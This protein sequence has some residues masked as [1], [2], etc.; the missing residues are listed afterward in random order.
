MTEYKGGMGSESR[1]RLLEKRRGQQLEALEI[2]KKK[3]SEN[4][5]SISSIESKFASKSDFKEEQLK[6]VTF[7]LVTHEEFL[8]KQESIEIG[9]DLAK[10]E[11]E[12]IM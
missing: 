4:S 7:G 6:Q 2:K 10:S 8:A 9:E 11:P 1:I 12:E 5:A 3:L